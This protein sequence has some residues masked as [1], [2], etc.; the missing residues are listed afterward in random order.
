[1]K[2]SSL[3]FAISL[4][5]AASTIHAAPTEIELTDDILVP[6]TIRFGLN[7]GAD[8][9]HSGAVLTKMRVVENFEGAQLRQCHFGPISAE[10]GVSTWYTGKHGDWDKF[11]LDGE[12]VLLSG[13]QQWQRRKVSKIT[14]HEFL[15]KGKPTPARFFLFDKPITPLPTKG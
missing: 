13:P 7:L 12:I 5:C 11:A 1:M 9:Y 3:A 8:S 4:L 14:T 15:H 2:H 6:D 10:D